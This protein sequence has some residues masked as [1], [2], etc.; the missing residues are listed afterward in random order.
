MTPDHDTKDW[1][2][3][4]SDEFAVSQ[5][6]RFDPERAQ[7]VINFFEKCLCLYEGVERDKNG[8]LPPF[9]PLPWAEHMLRRCFG[10]V[11]WLEET[12]VRRAGWYRRF[13]RC[14]NWVPKKNGKTPLGAGVGL[15]LWAGA[16]VEG[17][18]VASAARD[19]RQAE[20]MHKHSW[21]MAKHS[22]YFGPLIEQGKQKKETG[23]TFNQTKQ[24]FTY[25]PK[26]STFELMTGDNADSWDGYNGSI[27]LDECHVV[28]DKLGKIIERAGKSRPEPLLFG[29]ST[30]G[31]SDSVFGRKM[32]D[33]GKSVES[34]EI[35]DYTFLHVAHEADQLSTDEQCKQ[36][37]TWY[38]A[39]PALGVLLD[40]DEFRADCLA[41]QRSPTDWQDFKQKILNIWQGGAGS[42]IPTNDWK[43]GSE[44]FTE[45]DFFGYPCWIGM[46]LSRSLD[47]TAMVLCFRDEDDGKPVFR[48]LP[49][50]W[51]TERFVKMKKDKADFEGWIEDGHLLQI[52]G[53][54]IDQDV[55]F[56]ECE[57]LNELFDVQACFYDI[58]Y[59]N[60]LARKLENQCAWNMVEHSQTMA[61]M[62]GPTKLFLEELTAGRLKHNDNPCFNWHAGNANA[63]VRG[64]DVH[65]VKPQF[66]SWKK[67][68]AIVA[69]IMALNGAYQGESHQAAG[70]CYEDDNFNWISG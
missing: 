44:D 40:E 42:F 11:R 22:P 35:Q 61:H 43:A 39:N 28:G 54:T 24:Q 31:N 52:D 9:K 14:F 7:H 41:S 30:A 51:T 49:R 23:V 4:A 69:A 10:W 18:H 1:I 37:E 55:I 26:N 2:L 62:T 59:A 16:G 63:K 33:Y 57:R 3:N 17:Q 20:R 25:W 12:P 64:D 60:E 27:M 13:R 32:Y 34:G 66:G 65:I 29:I 58:K 38:S 70:Q 56:E 6:C 46:D 5:G 53:K 48:L 45:D 8:N 15:Y 36:P 19:G 67:I 21:L 68:D 50:I 47:M